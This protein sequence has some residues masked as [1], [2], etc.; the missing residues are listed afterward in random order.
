MCVEVRDLRGPVFVLIFGFVRKADQRGN[1]NASKAR[2][3]HR[4]LIF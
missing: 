2:T 4:G 3:D 1:T